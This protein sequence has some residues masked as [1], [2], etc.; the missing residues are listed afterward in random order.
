[1]QR[2]WKLIKEPR[3]WQSLAL[4]NW[5]SAQ[6]GILSVVTGAGKTVFA[7]LCMLQFLESRPNGCFVIVV[8]TLALLDQWYVSLTEDLA[9]SGDD[10]ALFSGQSR[11]KTPKKVNLLVLNTARKMA[12]QIAAQN[13]DNFLI[14]DECH[15]AGTP[16]NHKALQG[17]HAAT[18]G[19]SA[20]PFREHDEGFEKWLQPSLGP[21][22]FDYGY[23]Q[24]RHDNVITPFHL[25]NI[26]VNLLPHEEAEYQ[27]LSHRIIR[28]RRSKNISPSEREGRIERLL[29]RRAAVS[30]R[31]IMRI[32]VAVKL[33]ENY[34]RERCIV[35]H[36]RIEE[37]EQI[38]EML[39]HRGV[40][41]A[42]YHTKIELHVR[43]DNLRLFRRGVFDCLVTCRALDEG[44]NVP[45]TQYAII[46]SSTS[47]TRQRIQRLGRVLR[48]ALGKES[49]TIF[50]IYA[51][52]LE[53]RRL[54][55]EA[56]RMSEIAD[57]K[58]MAG[59]VKHD[60]QNPR[61]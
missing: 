24:A 26:S 19:L 20:T 31:A 9:V 25:V 55:H 15:R 61:E 2:Q 22:I 13:P 48:P 43:L 39:R 30:A 37:A 29:Q 6:Q 5:R 58:W 50:T 10:I 23:E 45:E 27:T 52:Q 28:L 8:P 32:P 59:A 7:Q 49:A 40:R 3:E 34:S 4:E 46:A 54:A 60:A 1:M 12:P 21:I 51:T 17:S 36:E 16:A 33:A 38:A 44:T 14:V 56:G 11:G 53:E 42:V 57:T 41:V 18:L 35:F 47:S